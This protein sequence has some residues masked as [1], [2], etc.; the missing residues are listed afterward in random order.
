MLTNCSIVGLP[1]IKMH[2]NS[3]WF[4]I[5]LTAGSIFVPEESEEAMDDQVGCCHCESSHAVA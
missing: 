2:Y 3:L 1:P 4:T 5:A